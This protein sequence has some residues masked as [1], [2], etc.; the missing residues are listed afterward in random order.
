LREIALS[1][2]QFTWANRRDTPTYEKLDRILASVE[3]EEKYP[4]TSVRA[5]TRIGSD[6]TPL[7][8]DF[9]EAAH[10]WKN[11]WFSFELSWLKTDGFDDLVKNE[12][13]ST[14]HGASPI[15][16]WQGKIRHLR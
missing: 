7:F 6:H 16:R 1:G 12:W 15:E 5:L 13:H 14:N 8:V 4:L 2:R 9:G 3:F 11:V 10:I